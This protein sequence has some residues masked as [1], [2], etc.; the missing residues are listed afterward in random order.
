MHQFL[1]A[2]FLGATR[3]QR[4]FRKADDDGEDDIPVENNGFALPSFMNRYYY[5]YY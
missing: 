4:G 2:N 5:Y 3:E 1:R